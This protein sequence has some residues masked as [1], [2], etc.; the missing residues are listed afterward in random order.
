[1][2]RNLK[3]RS[4]QRKTWN[5]IPGLKGFSEENIKLMRRFF[6]TW[7]DIETDSVVGTTEITIFNAHERSAKVLFV[8]KKTR[9][10][11]NRTDL[12]QLDRHK[13]IKE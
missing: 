6:E 3:Q 9:K 7:K 1:M 11:C 8:T 5:A 2:Q 10:S 12:L 13:E 4:N